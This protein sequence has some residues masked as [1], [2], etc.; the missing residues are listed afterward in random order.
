MR[1]VKVKEFDAFLDYL[2]SGNYKYR[3]EI[4]KSVRI[5]RSKL[6]DLKTVET[7][8]R[9]TPKQLG[10][11][12]RVKNNIKRNLKDKKLPSLDKNVIYSSWRKDLHKCGE[13]NNCYEI[14]MRAAY[15]RTAKQ[16]G[17]LTPELYKEGIWRVK[18]MRLIALGSLAKRVRVYECNGIDQKLVTTKVNKK[19]EKIWY[20]ICKVV[21]TV[22]NEV[23]NSLPENDFIYFWVDGI[24]FENKRNIQNIV[25]IFRKYG[26]PCKIRKIYKIRVEKNEADSNYLMIYENKKEFKSKG[27]RPFFL[28]REAFSE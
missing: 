22:I 5:V 20:S 14:D 21:G 10:F 8:K 28:S 13:I 4:S 6:G 25:K 26:Y 15:W 11:I 3:L 18:K 12:S 1:L 7:D 27:G 9:L 17:L 2:K 19:T 24:Y 16:L 23:K